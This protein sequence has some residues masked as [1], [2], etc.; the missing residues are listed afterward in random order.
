VNYY[1]F[2]REDHQ[3]SKRVTYK[4]NKE[5][6]NTIDKYTLVTGL[7]DAKEALI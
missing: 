5:Q 1:K 7:I 6:A 4:I 2:N 3:L